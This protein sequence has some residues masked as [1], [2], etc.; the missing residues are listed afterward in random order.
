MWFTFIVLVWNVTYYMN[1]RNLEIT[2]SGQ[3]CS[4]IFCYTSHCTCMQRAH[5]Y[6]RSTTPSLLWGYPIV[7]RLASIWRHYIRDS[8]RRNSA[9]L[10]HRLGLVLPLSPIHKIWKKLRAK[11][12]SKARSYLN[13]IEPVS[14][15]PNVP[16][17]SMCITVTMPRPSVVLPNQT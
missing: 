14:D 10:V 16:H 2:C 6:G 15:G 3:D 9:T 7:N 1:I 5:W 13:P 8:M 17:M 11:S 4:S 12:L